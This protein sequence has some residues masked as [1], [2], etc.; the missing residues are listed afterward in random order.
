MER[1]KE[2]TVKDLNKALRQVSQDAH[3]KNKALGLE[4]VYEKEGYIIR[5]DASGKEHKVKKLEEKKRKTFPR[6][7]PLN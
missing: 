4:T 3:R 5:M 6:V 2:I 7:I 1:R